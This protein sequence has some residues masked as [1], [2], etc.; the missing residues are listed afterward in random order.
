MSVTRAEKAR[1]AQALRDQGLLLREIAERMGA[2]L[3]TVHAWIADPDGSKLRARKDSYR[4]TCRECG[5][6][7]SGHA[8]PSKAAE[9][10]ASCNGRLQGGK[11]RL[12]TQE[13][14][15]ARIRE[16]N[17]IYGEPPAGPDWMPAKARAINDPERER[18]FLDAKGHWPNVVSVIRLFGTWN[19]AITAAGFTPRAPHGGGGNGQRQRKCKVAA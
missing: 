3:A 18:R 13:L 11:N 12:W 19:A 15:V 9:L 2:K 5:A 6:P 16:W 7:T 4:G 1:Q 17:D 10:C 14:V 8:G